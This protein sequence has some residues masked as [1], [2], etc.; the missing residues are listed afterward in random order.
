MRENLMRGD[1][2]IVDDRGKFNNVAVEL[3]NSAIAFGS[4][5]SAIVLKLSSAIAF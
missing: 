4:V 3:T 2:A 1:G 5:H